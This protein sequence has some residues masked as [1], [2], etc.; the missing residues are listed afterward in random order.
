LKIN[1]I[2]PSNRRKEKNHI[3]SS[4]DTEKASDKMQLKFGMEECF[5][6][7]VEGIYK[8]PAANIILNGNIILNECSLAEDGIKA[9]M[10]ALTTLTQHCT[11]S[12]NQSNKTK[13]K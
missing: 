7:L 5:L 6:S 4:T 9:R 8:S 12:P 3:I 13:I 2:H 10:S 1:V 11:R